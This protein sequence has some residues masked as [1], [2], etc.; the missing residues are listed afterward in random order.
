MSTCHSSYLSALKLPSVLE[1]AQVNAFTSPP[2]PLPTKEQLELVKMGTGRSFMQQHVSS[3]GNERW[4]GRLSPCIVDCSCM[5]FWP[6]VGAPKLQAIGQC[7]RYAWHGTVGG[8]GIR[9]GGNGSKL[10]FFIPW[11]LASILKF[12]SMIFLLKYG[13]YAVAPSDASWASRLVTCACL[14][15]H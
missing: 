7:L 2:A 1:P 14:R 9:D 11:G 12:G 4:A 13:M 5:A 15:M 6:Q 8:A 3:W 10:I